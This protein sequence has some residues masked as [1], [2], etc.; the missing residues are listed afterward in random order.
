MFLEK[1]RRELDRLLTQHGALLFRGFP[2]PS[3]TDF[4]AFVEALGYED[5]PY[6]GGAAVRTRV[7]PRVFTSNESPPSEVIP[8]HHE[9]AQTPNSPGKILFFCGT[10]P[11]QGGETPILHSGE[12]LRVL[13]QQVPALI[14]NLEEHGVRY[15]RVMPEHDDASSA[16]GRSWRSAFLIPDSGRPR[17]D[18]KAAERHLKAKG[19]AFEWL[20]NN[21]LR[22]ITPVL[23]PVRSLPDG[24]HFKQAFFNQ[25][26]AAYT[27]WTDARNTGEKA[28]LIATSDGKRGKHGTVLPRCD[29]QK[30]EKAHR[31]LQVVF[32]WQKGDV[33]VLDNRQ[34]MHA[35]NSFVPPRR[36]LASLASDSL[37]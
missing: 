18:R 8:F 3:A 11:P 33:L 23:H 1:H 34:C 28:V 17:R 9:L 25:I 27:G 6:V 26:V 32:A 10:A 5:F 21:D 2:L 4:S 22:T 7:A 13:R 15:V 35:R 20:A 36:I 16:L 24:A 30:V 12:L 37:Q 14:Q 31:D 29:M 19:Y